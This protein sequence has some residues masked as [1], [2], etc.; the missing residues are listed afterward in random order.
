MDGDSRDVWL[1]RLSV[2]TQRMLDPFGPGLTV[3]QV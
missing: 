3:V 2:V 1:K